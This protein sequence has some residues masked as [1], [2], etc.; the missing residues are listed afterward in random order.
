MNPSSPGYSC[1]LPVCLL[2]CL[3]NLAWHLSGLGPKHGHAEEQVAL[4]VPYWRLPALGKIRLPLFWLSL[5]VALDLGRVIFVAHFLR[6]PLIWKG[7]SI[8]YGQKHLL[9]VSAEA[10][11]DI[12]KDCF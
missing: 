7:C 1:C 3:E 11:G 10:R 6:V 12:Q 9:F 5:R 8:Q 2:L 4:S